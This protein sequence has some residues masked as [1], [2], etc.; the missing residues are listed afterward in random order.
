MASAPSISREPATTPTSS[1]SSNGQPVPP[2]GTKPHAVE[3]AELKPDG[4]CGETGN[5]VPSLVK[6]IIRPCRP[7][8]DVL[9][10]TSRIFGGGG[11]HGV[12]FLRF[13][14]RV[15]LHRDFVR[16]VNQ[17]IQDG[18]AHGGFTDGFVLVC[19]GNLADDDRRLPVI[20]IIQQFEQ[21]LPTLIC[22]GTYSKVIENQQVEVAQACQEPS[23]AVFQSNEI[24]L[25]RGR[26]RSGRPRGP[27][28]RRQS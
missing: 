21:I 4:R 6:C 8:D 25:V 27:R 24:E 13:S 9:R 12:A 22:H 28:R 16:C 15:S 1:G 23:P 19:E 3:P 17:T 20:S 7:L 14:H 26:R 2:Q 11:R 18:V 5:P 10:I